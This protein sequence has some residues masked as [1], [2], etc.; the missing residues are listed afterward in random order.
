MR[1]DLIKACL[2][3]AVVVVVVVKVMGLNPVSLEEEMNWPTS[4]TVAI[5]GKNKKKL[6]NG[7][8]AL[9]PGLVVMGGDSCFKGCEFESWHRILDGRVYTFICNKN[10]NV[11]FKRQK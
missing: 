9:G 7:A 10:C 11:C 5:K 3:I 8:G 2:E 4:W 1:T 6:K